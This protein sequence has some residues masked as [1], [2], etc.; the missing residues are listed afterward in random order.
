M[1]TAR[2]SPSASWP[3][4][5]DVRSN[6]AF[7]KTQYCRFVCPERGTS[8]HCRMVQDIRTGQWKIIQ[9]CSA[10]DARVRADSVKTTESGVRD[11]VETPVRAAGTPVRPD[12]QP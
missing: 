6:G 2:P 11:S 9:S 1:P 4:V 10:F 8:V 5:F 3:D 12:S 7:H